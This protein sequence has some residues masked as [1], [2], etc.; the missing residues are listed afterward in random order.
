MTVPT[1]IS[2]LLKDSRTIAVVGL[3][4]HPDRPSYEVAAYMQAQG[5]RIIP[6]NPTYAGAHILG[7]HCYATLTLA[8]Q[9]VSAE[10]GKIDIVDCFRRPEHIAA[11]VDEAIAIR[12]G[13][14]WMQLGIEDAV[15][16]ERAR[17]AGL[18]VVMD[19]CIKI[20]HAALVAAR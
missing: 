2:R 20:E 10:A 4:A 16:A 19:K 11:V 12:A 6:V 15:A 17:A 9:V 1:D 7:E 18:E 5:Y 8:A 14:V 13:S 3:S